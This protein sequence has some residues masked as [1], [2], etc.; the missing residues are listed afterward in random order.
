[1]AISKVAD[2]GSVTDGTGAATSVVD[3]PAAGSIAIDNYLIARVAVD[4]SGTSGAEPGLTISDPR[5]HTWTILGPALRDP[6]AA[7]AGATG[8]IAYVKVANAYTNGDDITFNWGAGNPPAKGIVIE[9]WTG[10]NKTTPIAVAFTF[11]QAGSAT[12]SVS[13]TPTA[14]GQLFYGGLATEGGP[15][16]SD[17]YTEDADSTDGSWVTLTRVGTGTTAS[18][19]TIS[20]A[21]KLVTGTSPQTWNPSILS[22]DHA[23]FA[24]VFDAEPSATGEAALNGVATLTVDG[25]RSRPGSATLAGEGTLTTAGIVTHQAAAALAATGTLTATGSVTIMGAAT[26]EGVATLTATAG[27]VIWNGEATLGGVGALTAAGFVSMQATATLAGVATVVASGDIAN[28]ATLSGVGSLTAVGSVVAFG[29]ASL[30]GVGTISVTGFTTITGSAS[31]SAV[32]DLVAA[33]LLIDPG[34]AFPV[35]TGLG[36]R[37]V[38]LTS[39]PF[40]GLTPGAPVES[41]PIEDEMPSYVDTARRVVLL[42]GDQG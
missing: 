15:A 36:L 30:A 21:Y 2:R 1:M 32:A 20:G 10:I 28:T 16:G 27:G 37:V 12:P 13:R 38:I 17:T 29:Q 7:N 6:G 34:D 5:S 31:L 39:D 8:Y 26:L 41:Q 22:R 4:N 18:G 14:A 19:M 42:T 3:L 25:Y 40:V 9:E 11:T 35:D 23:A 24:V 33:G